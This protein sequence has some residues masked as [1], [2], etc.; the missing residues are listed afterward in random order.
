MF[1]IS[2]DFS[3]NISFI[4][5]VETDSSYVSVMYRLF[6]LPQSDKI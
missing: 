1:W 2:L 3:I 4:P 5:F 6:E